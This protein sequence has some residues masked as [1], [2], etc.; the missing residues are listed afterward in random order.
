V[1]RGICITLLPAPAPA[2]LEE[3]QA[4]P[5]HNLSFLRVLLCFA[6][7]VWLDSAAFFIIQNTPALKPEPGRVQ[8]IFGRMDGCTLPPR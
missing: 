6:A 5:Q 7:L 2:P 8:L 4:L 3:A 1:P